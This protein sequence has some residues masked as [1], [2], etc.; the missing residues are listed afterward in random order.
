MKGREHVHPFA[1]EYLVYQQ[2][3]KLGY[4]ELRDEA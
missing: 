2:L 1:R 4:V 3:E